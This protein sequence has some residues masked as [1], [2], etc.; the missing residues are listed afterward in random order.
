ME[1]A[2]HLD[3]LRASSDALLGSARRGLDRPVPSCPG[4]DV[5]DLV[6]H[7]GLTWSWAAEI[8][9]TGAPAERDRPPSDRSEPS[10]LGWA[11]GR[12]EHLLATL[13][14]AEPDATCWTFGAPATN[15]FWA[16][17]QALET[18][19]HAWD[20]QAASAGPAAIDPEVSADGVDEYLGVMIPRWMQRHPE[21]GWS[22]ESLHLH[23]TDGDGEWVVRLGP[24][25][26]VS[27]DRAHSK[28]DVALRGP[29][30]GLWLWCCNRASLDAAGIAVFGDRSVA[31]RWT[32][33]ISF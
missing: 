3:V 23:R 9:R 6:V 12:A 27:T 1:T 4:W 5:A 7:I 16:R 21:A 28:A 13:G 24:E 15:R 33:E 17:R 10:L 32:S 11:A 20:V 14:A 19:L 8:V 22:G 18:V 31:D 30:E 29:A 2:D 25:G 26:A